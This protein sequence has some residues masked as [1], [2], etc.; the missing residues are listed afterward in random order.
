MTRTQKNTMFETAAQA[1]VIVAGALFA[2]PFVMLAA[3]VG[4]F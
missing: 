1:S 4:Q 2:V 3:F